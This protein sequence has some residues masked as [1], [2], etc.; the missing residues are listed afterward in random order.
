[1]PG[2]NFSAGLGDQLTTGLVCFLCHAARHPQERADYELPD[3]ERVA[4]AVQER[5]LAKLAAG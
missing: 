5:L 3:G 1:M 2:N 4:A